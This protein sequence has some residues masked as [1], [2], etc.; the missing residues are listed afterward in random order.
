MNERLLAV[1]WPNGTEGAARVLDL[2]A[3]LSPRARHRTTTHGESESASLNRGRP[4]CSSWSGAT[5]AH[6]ARRFLPG[7]PRTDAASEFG[8]RARTSGGPWRGAKCG[9][10]TAPACSYHTRS[11]QTVDGTTSGAPLFTF[12]AFKDVCATNVRARARA[13]AAERHLGIAPH[14]TLS[15]T[16]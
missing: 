2:L 14:L 15:M 1:D 5:D 10:P 7:R 4:A 16:I 6:I 12:K 13:R 11:P 8:R 9:L 3:G